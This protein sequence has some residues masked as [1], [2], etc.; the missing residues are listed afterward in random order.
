MTYSTPVGIN[1]FFE[2]FNKDRL[3]SELGDTRWACPK[4]GYTVTENVMV[5]ALYDYHCIECNQLKLSD[6][7]GFRRDK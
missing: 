1:P 7:I 6:F 5:D 3:L 2:E 4:C